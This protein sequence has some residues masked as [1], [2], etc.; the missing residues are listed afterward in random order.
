MS[1][2]RPPLSISLHEPQLQ[3]P[4]TVEFK[5]EVGNHLKPL[6]LFQ[7]S[8]GPLETCGPVREET[9][10]F[11]IQ[12]EHLAGDVSGVLN[13]LVKIVDDLVRETTTRKFRRWLSRD[14][15]EEFVP[16]V[17]ERFWYRLFDPADEGSKRAQISFS[18]FVIAVARKVLK[19]ERR[20]RQRCVQFDQRANRAYHS[21]APAPIT[22][23]D[24]L[25]ISE[26]L[27]SLP[28]DQQRAFTLF[29]YVGLTVPEIAASEQC[30]ERTV[31]NRLGAAKS[32]LRQI[33]S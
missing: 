10:I 25:L 21:Q 12:Q 18:S 19:N 4:D 17:S 8:T 6:E 7:S 2:C 15:L 24:A 3:H 29:H 22:L 31:Y 32:S 14:R 16:R 30:T 1:K 20:E 9:L 11:Y 13:D 27:R 28:P 33:I 26:S 23:D 5:I